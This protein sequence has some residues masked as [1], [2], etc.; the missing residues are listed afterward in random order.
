MITTDFAER[1]AAEWYAAW[2]SHDLEAILSHY[3]DG[4]VFH[5]PRIRI[6]S[7]ND[8]DTI[9]NKADLR[10]YWSQSLAGSPNLH[11]SPERLLMSS[12]ALTLIYG[13]HRMKIAAE[14]FVFDKHGLVVK[15]IA[16]HEQ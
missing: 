1:F 13:N 2:N 4:I 10:T 6:V 11:F 5:S 7:G 12:D 15:S 14:T 16:A 9:T 8:T 3:A